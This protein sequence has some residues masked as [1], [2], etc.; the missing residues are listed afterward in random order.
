M[1]LLSQC[2]VAAHL[3][4]EEDA[5]RASEA[6]EQAMPSGI[7]GYRKGKAPEKHVCMNCLRKGI[8]CEWVKGGQGKSKIFF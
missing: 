8:E 2:K 7:A 1:E 3:A 5:W 6:S 4:R